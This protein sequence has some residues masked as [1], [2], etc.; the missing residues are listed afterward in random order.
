MVK[1]ILILVLTIAL[2]INAQ[3][4]LVPNPSFEEF[5]ICPDNWGQV[6]NASGWLKLKGSPDYFN[7]CSS[8]SFSTPK[9]NMGNQ[10]PASGNSYIGLIFYSRLG[11]N[12]DEM[13]GIQ[14]NQSMVVGVRYF[15]SFK[16]VL[17]YNSPFG[18]V[19]CACNKLSLK[20]SK[21]LYS[22]SSPPS[23]NNTAHF[24]TNNVNSDTLNWS[25]AFGSFVADSTYSFLSLGNFFSNGNT[26]INDIIPS[27][28][29]AYYFIDDICISTDSTFTS[30][31]QYTGITKNNINSDFSPFPNP[32][33]N[34]ISLNY[35]TKERYS[36]KVYNT[37]GQ[38]LFEDFTFINNKIIETSFFPIGVYFISISNNQQYQTYKLIKQ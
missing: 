12:A 14:L 17:K 20:F 10:V 13:L 1:K 29:F 30:N 25:K 3:V 18:G 22:L 5:S 37:L 23:I 31:Y 26:N 36:V 38:L 34:Y 27:N 21:N 15:I 4:N 33:N 2:K 11:L 32:F 7:S 28:D 9:N 8:Y 16:N 35:P 19:C 24:F 6:I